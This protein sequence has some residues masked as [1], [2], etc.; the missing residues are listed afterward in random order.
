M[1]DELKLKIILDDGS[2]KEGFLS[3]EKSA[4]KTTKKLEGDFSSLTGGISKGFLALGTVLA[5]ALAATKLVG[6]LK[7]SAKAAMEA[8][9]A[10][11]ALGSS[12]A[13]IGKFSREAVDSFS[14][15]ASNLQA[16]T[17]IGDDLIKQNAALLVSVGNL[18]G[19]GLERGTKAA[20]DLSRA[21]QIDVSSSFDLVA[22]AAQGNTA[23]LGRYGIKLD[24][25]IPKGQKWAETLA[26]IETRF[27]G[28]A[29]TR[30]NTLEGSL[31]NLS[32][33]FGE[34]EEA[35]GGVFTNSGSLRGAINF[36]AESFFKLSESIAGAV[37]G[38]DV[39][40]DLLGTLVQIAAVLNNFI[41][42]PIELFVRSF[43]F[44]IGALKLGFDTLVVAVVGFS[45]L[46]VEAIVI[47][48]EGLV[49]G[50][51][52]I[53]SLVNKDLG[54]SLQGG[55]KSFREFFTKPLE[56]E[57]TKV[58][59]IQE[60][61]F[62]S[63]ADNADSVFSFKVTD[64]VNSWLVGFKDSMEQGKQ[65]T[66]EFKNAIQSI[67]Q[68]VT[69]VG[70]LFGEFVAGFNAQAIEFSNSAK[71]N[72]QEVGKQAF[73]TLGTGIGNAFAKFGQALASGEDAGKAFLDSML[74]LFADIA[75]QLGTSFILQGIAYSLNPATPGLGG[76]LIGAGAALA[77]FGGVLKAL[78]GGKSSA[79]STATNS[80]GGIAASPGANT[81]LTPT[82]E[83][84][85]QEPGTAVSV[86]IQGDVLDSDESGSRIVSLINSAFDK[87]GVV[88]SQG[89]FA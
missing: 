83:L 42:A 33:A 15:Y 81:E 17:G 13:Q 78:S 84:T 67:E 44:G 35:I 18:S 70:G 76:P 22:K 58:T 64:S 88:I 47:P 74:G 4:D 19:Q 80:G 34:V 27:G 59:G 11:N 46:L 14:N 57:L 45:K 65:A 56:D 26:L 63:L 31:A 49:S 12:L 41:V 89:A 1:A 10:T 52:K 20:L 24:E 40:K 50:I 5:G 39:L 37:K 51:G 54:E 87:K 73:N 77:T 61:T 69:S 8:E 86:V 71:K 29:E 21:L 28:L 53:A 72:F 43:I 62:N 23:A 32:N 79:S 48:I 36:V 30:L 85:R 66:N 7:D 9:T 55:A 16:T 3:L 82:Q 6:F 75:I 2:V 60:K 38:K 68:P 25:S